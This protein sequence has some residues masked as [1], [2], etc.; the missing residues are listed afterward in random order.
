[1]KAVKFG[2]ILLF[3][4][5][6]SYAQ[7]TIDGKSNVISDETITYTVNWGEIASWINIANVTWSV[8]NGTIISSDKY[9]ATVVWDQTP[10]WLNG[11]GR[12]EVTDDITGSLGSLDVII[13]NFRTTE[14]EF[15]NGI[16]GPRAIF[17]NFGS[18]NNP[19]LPLS[20]SV[21]TYNYQNNCTLTPNRY[22]IINSTVG[23]STPWLG[24]PVDHTPN[25]IN[26]YM[27][28]IDGS[29]TNSEVF[30][31][32]V[33]G[34]ATSFKYEF[35]AWVANLANP[36][37]PAFPSIFQKPKLSFY[38][39]DLSGNII[40]NSSN[41]LIEYNASSPWQQISFMFALP[42]G[43]S[44][45]QVVI[46][47]NNGSPDGNDYVIDDISFA[48][49]YS[50]LLASFSST[51]I[52]DIAEACNSGT[53]TIYASWPTTL[54][55]FSNPSYQWE[56]RSNTSNIW[57]TIL[58]ANSLSFTKNE[59]SSDIYYYRVKAYDPTNSNLFVYSN[60]LTFFVQKVILTTGITYAL[61][62]NP[63]PVVLTP[64]FSIINKNPYSSNSLTFN[65]TPATNLSS[66]I[67]A[68]PIVTIPILPIN[69]NPASPAPIVYTYNYSLLVSNPIY[70]GCSAS[71]SYSVKI[72][73]PRP[74]AVPTIFHPNG[75]VVVNQTFR[76]FN[77]EDYPGSIQRV[78]SRWGQILFESNG[79]TLQSYQ[80]NGQYQGVLQP[81][82]AYVWQLD[83]KGCPSPTI[84]IPNK[85]PL[86]SSNA[87]GTVNL[88]Y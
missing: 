88:A 14:S 15:C 63:A 33:T 17:E 71:N 7:V 83:I 5:K 36:N 49:C 85:P 72:S 51:S 43:I 18:G 87:S 30:R 2:L 25:D 11:Q 66:S 10:A 65:W 6:F 74:I 38:I 13:E 47:N 52:V 61:A 20:A 39:F 40:G 31:K 44:S 3:L 24:I 69:T 16:L 64:N 35:S 79:P 54:L 76:A 26:G 56:R 29:Q 53:K 42:L 19:G 60:E 78:Y 9:S 34:L 50:P 55:P 81:L 48:P 57:Q 4:L 8:N 86:Y 77:I 84:L 46:V 82:G 58:G 37:D 70:S 12:L 73:S 1:M 62:C 27:M 23:C 32:T 75:N 45:I 22:T 21:T 80:W 59:N 67:V 28:M 41:I 68:N